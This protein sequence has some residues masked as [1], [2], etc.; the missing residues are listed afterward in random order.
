MLVNNV[1]MTGQEKAT[2]SNKEA[3][4]AKNKHQRIRFYKETYQEVLFVYT[5]DQIMTLGEWLRRLWG[6]Y[7][8]CTS[9]Q[10]EYGGTDDVTFKAWA[11]PDRDLG[12]D[13]GF[14]TGLRSMSFHRKLCLGIL[15]TDFYL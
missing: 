6:D 5:L 11:T 14:W 12:Y 3:M 7:A 9:Q 8:G 2:T 15:S 1:E 13:D 10:Q 4:P